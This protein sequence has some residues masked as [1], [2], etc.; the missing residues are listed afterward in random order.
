MTQRIVRGKLA[1]LLTERAR[2]LGPFVRVI[3]R[4]VSRWVVGRWSRGLTTTRVSGD[5][6][7]SYMGRATNLVT[8]YVLYILSADF[9]HITAASLC[10]SIVY[11]YFPPAPPRSFVR[12]HFGRVRHQLLVARA[13]YRAHV[14]PVRCS[15][16]HTHA[17]TYTHTT[18]LTAERASRLQAHG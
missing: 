5:S 8:N 14:R 9:A 16:I 6:L 10:S 3:Q 4:W 17:R 13:W 7:V 2:R 12:G 11:L 1:R 18:L 15:Y